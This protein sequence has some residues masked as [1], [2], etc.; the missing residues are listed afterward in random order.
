MDAISEAIVRAFVATMPLRY[1]EI[2][3]ATSQ[4]EHAAIA[5][6]RRSSPAYAE[7][8]REQPHGGAIMCIVADDQ[9]GLLSRISAALVVHELDVVAAQAYT[10]TPTTGAEAVDFFWVRRVDGAETPAAVTARDAARVSDVL[11]SLVAGKLTIDEVARDA[12]AIRARPA[13]ATRVRFDE[14]EDR[15]L[16]V[17]TVETGDRPGL[18]LA[19]SQ[20][21]FRRRVQI[22]WTEARSDSGN[23]VDRFHLAEFDGAPVR[24]E[25]RRLIQADILEAIARL[26]AR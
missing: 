1:R 12:R 6:R 25:T 24:E 21:L 11:S 14:G 18:L 19:I 22:V 16:A 17:L 4:R 7:V 3:D 26:A 13:G 5:M 23:A 15:G 9:P 20:A 8:W 10:R 2:F